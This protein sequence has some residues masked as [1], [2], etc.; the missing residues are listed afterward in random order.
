MFRELARQLAPRGGQIIC[1]NRPIFA[2][3]DLFSNPKRWMQIFTGQTIKPAANITVYRPKLFVHPLIARRLPGFHSY[4]RKIYRKQ[5]ER[6]LNEH[7]L[8]P[9][10]TAWWVSHPYHFMEMD[11]PHDR[12]VVYER[13]DKYDYS[14]VLNTD[15]A[16]LVAGLDR[17]LAERADLIITTS[18]NLAG[19]LD[20]FKAK[21]QCL[22]N[23][24]DYE[25]FSNVGTAE[26]ISGALADK[27]K[28]PVIGYLGTIHE[29]L[30]ILLI[31]RLA[32]IKKEWTFMLAGPVQSVKLK[33][34]PAFKI[35]QNMPNVVMTGWLDWT[36]LPSYLKLFDVGIIP[37]RLD[38]GFNQYVDPNK[39]H[40]YMA[41]GLPVVTTSLPEMG[42][43]SE[44][45][46]TADTPEAFITAIEKVLDQDSVLLRAGRKKY[47]RENGWE[48][49]AAKII[50]SLDKII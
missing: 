32:E 23:S 13:Y 14:V 29:G 10:E 41:M 22:P 17:K 9:K 36:V 6:L 49:R 31:S 25:Y 48:Q 7:S 16:S 30:D 4:Q 5:I 15:L 34:D 2:V 38:C 45:V 50:A 42:K 1:L 11:L 20:E 28:K 19:E 47:A 26:D 21:V 12:K 43:Y 35:M 3:S 44:W 33:N 27:I 46:E 24:A 8:S 18:V 39:F 40:E 37:Y